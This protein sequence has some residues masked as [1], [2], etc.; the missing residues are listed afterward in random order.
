MEAQN[1]SN[2][3]TKKERINTLQPSWLN[4]NIFKGWLV[5][6][7]TPNKVFCTVC[8]MIIA[9]RKT[10]LVKHS[11]SATHREKT[12]FEDIV[13]D[14]QNENVE[15]KNVQNGNVQSEN[16]QNENIQSENVQN[17]N[18]Q[19]E[20]IQNVNK[21]DVLTHVQKVK[22]A[23]IKLAAFFVEHDIPYQAIERFLPIIKDIGK[24]PEVIAN[25]SFGPGNDN[26]Q[27]NMQRNEEPKVN[28]MIANL[29]TC[30]FSILLDE[31]VVNFKRVLCVF[32]QY[33]SPQDKRITTQLLKLISLQLTDHTDIFY[34]EF[35]NLFIKEKIPLRNIVAVSAD[36]ASTMT[37]C[38]AI[39]SLLKLEIPELVTLSCIGYAITTIVNEACKKLPVSCQN[40][41]QDIVSHISNN[42]EESTFLGEFQDIFNT[43]TNKILYSSNNCLVLHKCIVKLIENWELVKNYFIHA[44]TENEVKSAAGILKQ[45]NDESIKAYI[46]FFKYSL[47]Y[48]N[49]LIALYQSEKFVTHTLFEECRQLSYVVAQHFVTPNALKDIV[50]IDL[51]DPNNI[52]TV[53]DINVGPECES[54]LNTL[55]FKRKTE[56]RSN[57][58]EFYVTAFLKMLECLPYK[59]TMLEQ[60]MFLQPSIALYYEG[61]R[62]IRDLT[63]I[64]MRL[65]HTD[66]TSLAYEWR[67]LP[68]LYDDTEKEELARLEVDEMWQQIL[69]FENFDGEKMFPN[70][71]VLVESVLSFPHSNSKAKHI[72]SKIEHIN[73]ET[74]NEVDNTWD[75]ILYKFSV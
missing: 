17:E 70:L 1:N 75:N 65:G 52:L 8:N 46:L 26:D 53:N 47:Q 20:N 14:V 49:H 55:V 42:A 4:D 7:T 28:E 6:L 54:F 34:E 40:F 32:V 45:L 16:V 68:T 10:N 56:I 24:N 51:N 67:I 57:C 38:N 11:Q 21:K 48:F 36:T 33:V 19:S 31:G 30:K 35:K 44:V 27:N 60:L 59:D 29:R 12:S 69:K 3:T 22:R 50:N 23:E 74:D 66:I 18:V 61:R 62:Q 13:E 63:V 25:L 64:A 71:E 41:I 37:V 5:P 39:K 43:E 2:I 9:C 72:L 15:S 58:L 73:D